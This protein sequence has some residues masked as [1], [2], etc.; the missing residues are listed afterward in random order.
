[1][2]EVGRLPFSMSPVD[3]EILH[4]GVHVYVR[5][6]D[7]DPAI[8]LAKSHCAVHSKPFGVKIFH[9]DAHQTT[10]IQ[11]LIFLP[12]SKFCHELMVPVSARHFMAFPLSASGYLYKKGGANEDL[13]RDGRRHKGNLSAHFCSDLGRVGGG[14]VVGLVTNVLYN[15]KKKIYE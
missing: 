7:L 11:I 3:H 8:F 1:M 6:K 5:T 4:N 12:I 15:T 10:A 2:E 13:V 9:K 14:G